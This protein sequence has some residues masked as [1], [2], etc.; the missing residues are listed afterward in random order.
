[1]PAL[2][3]E[4]DANGVYY[5]VPDW[6]DVAAVLSD[7]AG[8]TIAPPGSA[9]ANPTFNVPIVIRNASGMDGMA[10]A[11]MEALQAQGFT[12]VSIDT[13]A[14]GDVTDYTQIVDRSN[15][16]ATS[17]YLAGIIG[18]PIDSV[19]EAGVDDEAIAIEP[20]D[21]RADGAISI[22]IGGDAPDPST[23]S[24]ASDLDDAFAG[25]GL[26]PEAA[27]ESQQQRAVVPTS[28][29]AVNYALPATG[30]PST[31]RT[32]NSG[33]LSGGPVL[34]TAEPTPFPP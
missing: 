22:T 13:S 16:L 23:Y 8:T 25:Y 4:T 28:T 3:E 19:L 33:D 12:N 1:M 10:T 15:N 20:Y 24:A 34:P 21:W 11:V 2:T 32:E 29:P 9:L 26:D 27:R 18:V 31:M 14:T 30:D 6:N 7:F 5:L 17:M